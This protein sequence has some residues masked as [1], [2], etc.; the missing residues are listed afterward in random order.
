MSIVIFILVIV[1]LILVHEF[2]HFIAAK[3]A[4]MRVDEFGIGFPPRALTIAK[5]GD[6]S[7]TLNWIPFGGFVSIFGENAEAKDAKSAPRRPEDAGR[8]FTDKNRFAQACVLIAGVTMNM[9]FAYV[10]IVAALISGTP[11]AL[12]AEELPRAENPV[13][14]IAAILPGSPAERAGLQFGD[15]I[16]TAKSTQGVWQEADAE[17]F[18]AF[19]AETHGAEVDLTVK[20]GE[21]TIALTAT[22]DQGVVAADPE[23]FALGVSVA[24]VGVVPLPVPEAIVEGSYL[25]WGSTTATAAGLYHFFAGIF[26]FNADLSQVSG[27]IGIAGAVGSASASGLGNLFALM[28]LIS[29]NLAIINLLPIPALDGGRLLFVGIEA[30]TRRSVPPAVVRTVHGASFIFLIGLMV[31]ITVSDVF[32]L[33]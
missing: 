7:Y 6:T 9:V 25:T 21:K 20:R 10:L 11:R 2:G 22:P 23:R 5:K 24:S 26:T 3:I 27:P 32:K 19:M 4:G 31:V 30:L 18:T 8:A 28:A 16:L 12:T 1:A 13:L 15:S 33:F 17:S 14:S 29:I